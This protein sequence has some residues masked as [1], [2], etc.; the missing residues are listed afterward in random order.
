MRWWNDRSLLLALLLGLLLRTLP[1]AIWAWQW[2]CVRD[3]CTYFKLAASMV[4]GE[5]MTAASGGWLWAPGYPA[6]MALHT[7]LFGHA[8]TVR[9]TQVVIALIATV[10]LYRL[11]GA[12]AERFTSDTI[13]IRRASRLAAWLYAASL[14]QAFFA[15]G[16][17][18]EVV[19]TGVLL[20]ALTAVLATRRS[21]GRRALGLALLTG[22]CVGAC[23]L[24]RGVATYM[25][26]IFLVAV[27]WGRLR[28]PA[29]WGQM[30]AVLLGA[31]LTVAP[32]SAYASRTFQTPIISDRTLGQMMWLGNNDFAPITFD[33]GNGPLSGREYERVIAT[34]RP[35]CAPRKDTIRRDTCEVEAGIAWIR[36]HPDVFLIRVPIRA[37]QLLNP[38]SLLTRHLRWGQWPGLPL[39]V[40]EL[41]ILTG[42]LGSM[43][44][45]WLGPIG[46]LARTRSAFGLLSGG[47]LLY[48][49]A[50]IS[51]L[52]G[53]SRY[54]IPLEPFL[55]IGTA[56]LLADPRGAWAALRASPWRLAASAVA[57]AA[58]VPLV[59]WYLPAGWPQWRRW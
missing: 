41:I 9:G 13:I 46:L 18:S 5:G 32:Y 31:V 30:L 25:L 23:V 4:A 52:A 8:T 17:W 10:L 51:L 33:Y 36:A 16:A 12:L 57:L 44:I 37:A 22:A 53:L 29:A 14:P 43:L 26:P 21:A 20:A 39:W 34:G 35:F 3:E 42:A 1:M 19:Y 48:H 54:R 15:M 24:F 11:A 38:H 7:L 50:A 47:I 45:L 40:D 49:L 55:M 28:H 58:L 27:L 6:L 56:L 2:P 59:L